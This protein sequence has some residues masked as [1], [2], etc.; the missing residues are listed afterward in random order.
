MN[1]YDLTFVKA[2][3]KSSVPVVVCGGAG[4]LQDITEAVFDGGASAVPAG[5]IFI[6]HGKRQAVLITYPNAAELETIFRR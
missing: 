1:G 5:S 3:S 6:F 4:N 2:V